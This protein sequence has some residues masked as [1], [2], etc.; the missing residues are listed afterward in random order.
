MRLHLGVHSPAMMGSR[1]T[2][3]IHTHRPASL[4]ARLSR[5]R[6]EGFGAAV[7]AQK[8]HKCIYV[9]PNDRK[10]QHSRILNHGHEDRARLISIYHPSCALETSTPQTSPRPHKPHKSVLLVPP[11]CLGKGPMCRLLLRPSVS[12]PLRFYGFTLLT[13]LPRSP[14]AGSC[15]RAQQEAWGDLRL[16][17]CLA[18][19]GRT[20]QQACSAGALRPHAG[21]PG[22]P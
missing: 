18:R 14:G 12:T 2:H 5:W 21:A 8:S 19:A 4:I 17:P 9:P 16:T 13:W 6:T 11:C 22:G 3:S 10:R 7:L 1:P 15:L 20:V